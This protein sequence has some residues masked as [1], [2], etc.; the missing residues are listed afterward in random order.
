MRTSLLD[1]VQ[2]VRAGLALLAFVGGRD[3]DQQDGSGIAQGL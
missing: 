3:A 1:S 2:S